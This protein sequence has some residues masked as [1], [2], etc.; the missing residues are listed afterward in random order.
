MFDKCSKSK[1][2]WQ[3]YYLTLWESVRKFSILPWLKFQYSFKNT[4]FEHTQNCKNKSLCFSGNTLYEQKYKLGAGLH[5]KAG[6][7]YF[8]FHQLEGYM[9]QICADTTIS[10]FIG[11]KNII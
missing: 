9:F 10:L 1:I 8:K 2:T 4:L 11:F 3:G 5:E 7:G 6:S